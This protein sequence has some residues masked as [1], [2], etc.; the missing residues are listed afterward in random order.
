MFFG[1]F[2]VQPDGSYGLKDLIVKEVV[3]IVN[4]VAV[5]VAVRHA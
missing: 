1:L 3:D 5:I 2:V 4:Y